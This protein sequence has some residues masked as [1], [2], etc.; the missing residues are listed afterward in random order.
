MNILQKLSVGAMILPGFQVAAQ[1]AHPNIILIMTDQQSY[2]TIS[3]HADLYNEMYSSTPNIDRLVKEGISFTR[4]YC[5]NPVSVPSRFALFTGKY[6]GQYGIRENQ[7]TSADEKE[8]RGLLSENGMGVVF[9]RG[10]YDT[11]YGGKVHLPFSDLQGRSKFALPKGYGFENCYTKDERE[12]L[13]TEV[14]K[15]L[16]AKGTEVKLDKQKKPFLLVASFLNPHDICIE[17]SSNL[18]PILKGEK[19][20]DQKTK[21]KVS[22]IREIRNK[23]AAID[24]L[25]FYKNY[26]PQLPFNFEKTKGFPTLKKSRYENFPDYY[27]RKYRWIY[28]ELVSLVDSHVGY[29]L[30]ALDR[31]PEL[32][33]NTIVVFTSDHGE[34]QGAHQMITKSLPYDECQRVPFIFCGPGIKAGL[35]DSS[36]VC[37]G[38][39][40]LPTLCSLAGIEAPPTD[41]LSLISRM[42]GKNS[43]TLRKALYI[44]GDGFLNVVS[45]TNK[46]TLFDGK[47][48]G[49]EMLIDLSVDNGELINIFPENEV[50]AHELKQYIPTEK[51]KISVKKTLNSKKN[52]SAKN[53]K[54]F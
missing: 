44:E 25:D 16:D 50:R 43:K 40:L 46:Y 3:A 28:G 45:Q 38:V 6:G 36:L 23:I 47:N 21:L 11:Y 18:S 24:S 14:A 22:C 53:R 20:I 2:N 8:V 27:W 12:G 51:L 15:I 34:M 32:K 4:T 33:R 9:A 39:D 31:N 5:S 7:C 26:A 49:K 29:I 19:D 54:R 10:G 17:G 37:N 42:G 1:Q 30:D 41:G 48:I 13:G 52:K 35:R